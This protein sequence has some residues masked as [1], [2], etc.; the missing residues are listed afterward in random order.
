MLQ[1]Q[2]SFF[3]NISEL[4]NS[5]KLER[6]DAKE[7]EGTLCAFIPLIK[8]SQDKY[9]FGTELKNISLK[10][11]KLMVRVGGGYDDFQTTLKLNAFM[12][13]IKI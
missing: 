3:Q 13:V 2:L 1:Y 5:N 6:L 10:G 12:E 9:Y 4:S 11:E 7:I 8:I